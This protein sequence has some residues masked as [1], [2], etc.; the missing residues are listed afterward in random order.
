[1][2]AST[3]LALPLPGAA[4]P[5]ASAQIKDPAGLVRAIQ[6]SAVASVAEVWRHEK[7][8]LVPPAVMGQVG[9]RVWVHRRAW[10]GACA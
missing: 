6:A 3:F 9:A 4:G 8:P 2:Q 7:L 1:M 10:V 5:A